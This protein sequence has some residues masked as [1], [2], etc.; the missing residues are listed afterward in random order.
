MGLFKNR[1]IVAS[2][3]IVIA[4]IFIFSLAMIP[5]INPAPHRLPIAIV[6]EDQGLTAS[7]VNMGD[8]VV[9]RW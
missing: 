4:V 9:S 2:P 6:N 5:S 3:L 8:T 1:L 7:N